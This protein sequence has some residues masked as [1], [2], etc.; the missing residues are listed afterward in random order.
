[1][2]NDTGPSVFRR[3]GD[4]FVATDL[5][6]GPWDAQALHGGAPAAL[7]AHVA[8]Q[9]AG[10]DFLL[11]RLTFELSRPVPLAA[12]Q[13]RAEASRGRSARR[14]TLKIEHD[15]AVVGRAIALMLREQPVAVPE[16][17]ADTLLPPPEQCSAGFETPGMPS[18]AFFHDQAMEI[19]VATGS[20][21]EPGPAAAWFRPRVALIEGVTSSAAMR[22]AAASDFG[23]G[24]S[25]VLPFDDYLF[26][27]TDLTVYLH[28]LPV[29]D[30]IG[31]DAQTIA[32]PN[33]VGLSSSTLYDA[34]GRIGMAHQN[35]LI[36]QR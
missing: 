31:V 14:V 19:R 18:G 25:W 32:Q 29:G 4:Y 11:A 5:A 26:T 17:H 20:T 24:L 28:R 9:T 33:G 35:L 12:L 15:G 34:R 22:A 16:V 36:R 7:L 8:E 21:R 6:R 27:N 23:N 1:M 2:A 10:H 13:V 30:W 3:D